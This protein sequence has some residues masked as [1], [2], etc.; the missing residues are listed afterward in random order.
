MGVH[1][2]AQHQ[3]LVQEASSRNMMTWES[4]SCFKFSLNISF[5]WLL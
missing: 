2:P 3:T 1:E 5:L 4:H